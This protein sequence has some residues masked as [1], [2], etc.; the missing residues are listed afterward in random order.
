MNTVRRA[1]TP[2]AVHSRTALALL[3]ST[4]LLTFGTTFPQIFHL[5]AVI[6]A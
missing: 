5:T 4:A 6:G 2:A 1:V 3:G